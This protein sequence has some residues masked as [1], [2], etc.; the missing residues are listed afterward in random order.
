M[1][2]KGL[3][4]ILKRVQSWPATAQQEALHSLRAIEQDFFAG[5]DTTAELDRSNQEA[6]RGDDPWPERFAE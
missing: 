6:P 4:Y 2:T 1:T 5:S 3:R